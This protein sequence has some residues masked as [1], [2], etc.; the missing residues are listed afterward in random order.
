MRTIS[1]VADRT[2]SW[3]QPA[4]L[5]FALHAGNEQV[6]SLAFRSMF[7]TQATAESGDEA[8]TFKR[9]GFFHPRVTVRRTG[10][11]EDV[12]TFHNNTWSGGGSLVVHGGPTFRASTNFW[13]TKFEIG[14]A[15]G[16]PLVRLHYGGIFKLHADVEMLPTARALPELA[17]IVLLS[18][19]LA[20]MLYRDSTD[21]AAMVATTS[22]VS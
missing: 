3:S 21:A 10:S 7:G 6:G 15:A 16:E 5:V 8:W 19:Y 9:T 17:L 2:L 22:A 12:A 20:L 18:W 11:D 14:T 4:A 13:Q 1:S